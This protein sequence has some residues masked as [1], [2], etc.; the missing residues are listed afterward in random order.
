MG[1]Y[2]W[3]TRGI[4]SYDYLRLTCPAQDCP[5]GNNAIVHKHRRFGDRVEHKRDWSWDWSLDGY[6]CRMIIEADITLNGKIELE[7]VDNGH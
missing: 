4:W 6:Y 2:R 3:C 5:N 7:I 1:S